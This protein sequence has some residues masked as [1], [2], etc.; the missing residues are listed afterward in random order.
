MT[1]GTGIGPGAF[2]SGE[3]SER[4]MDGW[5]RHTG[6]QRLQLGW[7]LVC[8]LLLGSITV[9]D[10]AT[11]LSVL[12]PL[13]LGGLGIAWVLGLMTLGFRERQQ[14]NAMVEASAFSRQYGP[15]TSDIETIMQ[16]RSVTASTTVPSLFA[17]TH[18]QIK[19]GVTG[20]DASFSVTVE[21]DDTGESPGGV[22]TGNEE[23]DDRFRIEGSR[24]NVERILSPAVQSALVDI[25]VPGV[26]TVT[27]DAVRFTVPFTNLSPEELETLGDLVV[28]IAER[29]EEVGSQ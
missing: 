13:S 27:G 29:V 20:V 23:L 2:S 24:Q 3:E 8:L 4:L 18:T 25:R 1:D 14:W 17:Q 21:V 15:Q 26:C 9:V 19:T 6:T 7:S 12:S 28:T 22:S 11:G 10:T 16:G 5:R